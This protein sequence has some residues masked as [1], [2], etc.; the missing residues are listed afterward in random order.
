MVISAVF[1][2]MISHPGFVFKNNVKEDDSE[3]TPQSFEMN[4][5]HSTFRSRI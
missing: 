2:L 3:S 1:C 5:C 4:E